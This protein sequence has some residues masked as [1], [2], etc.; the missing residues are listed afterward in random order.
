MHDI[1]DLRKNLIKYKKKFFDRNLDFNTAFFEKLD[2]ANRKLISK[3]EKLE[4]EK[5]LLSKSKDKLNFDKSKI[6]S[7]EISKISKEQSVTQKEFDSLLNM[8]PNVALDDVPVGSDE[9]KNK[10]IKKVGTPNKFSFKPKSHT[11]I[12]LKF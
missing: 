5:K 3:K 9:K 11:E 1:K 10:L 2:N 4:Q 6:I 8:L 12:G 7:E